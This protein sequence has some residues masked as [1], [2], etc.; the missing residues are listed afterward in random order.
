MREPTRGIGTLGGRQS[1]LDRWGGCTVRRVLRAAGGLDA[2]PAAVA[3]G[4]PWQGGR[5]GWLP[6]YLAWQRRIYLHKGEMCMGSDLSF[7]T[8]TRRIRGPRASASLGRA[9]QRRLR[10]VCAGRR[11]ARAESAHHRQELRAQWV[12]EHLDRIGAAS[13]LAS[14]GSWPHRMREGQNDDKHHLVQ[15][16]PRTG[17]SHGALEPDA[18]PDA[19]AQKEAG[20]ILITEGATATAAA[21]ATAVSRPLRSSCRRIIPTARFRLLELEPG[22]SSARSRARHS[23]EYRWLYILTGI[24]VNNTSPFLRGCDWRRFEI[25]PCHAPSE[26]Q[27]TILFKG[28]ASCYHPTAVQSSKTSA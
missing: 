22:V 5:Q 4:Q 11:G 16:R 24:V 14:R 6:A 21:A 7:E 1:R 27:N 2:V 18:E 26:S 10:S 17:T 3:A 19:A 12:L 8:M 28:K 13:S 23:G 20:A 25:S 15:K 9:A